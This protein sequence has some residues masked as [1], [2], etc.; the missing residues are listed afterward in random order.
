MSQ[1][2][3]AGLEFTPCV[4]EDD[5]EPLALL[6]YILTSGT[7]GMP[8]MLIRFIKDKDFGAEHVVR[9]DRQGTAALTVPGTCKPSSD[10]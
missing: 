5:P 6:Y 10:L 1:V 9:T 4:A 3:Q 7:T 8:T 2:A